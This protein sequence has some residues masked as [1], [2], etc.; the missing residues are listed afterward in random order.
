M[1]ILEITGNNKQII[2]KINAYVPATLL[3]LKRELL[4]KQLEE[5][6]VVIDN[7]IDVIIIDK[8]ENENESM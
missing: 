1:K 3:Q 8:G 4:L 7:S 2:F 6:V 5:G